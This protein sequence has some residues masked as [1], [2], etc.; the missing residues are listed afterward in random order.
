MRDYEPKGYYNVE[1]EWVST[2]DIKI[3]TEEEETAMQDEIFN[4][5]CAGTLD[6]NDDS[7][8]EP[9]D[10]EIAA[11]GEA[12]SLAELEGD[13]EFAPE[14]EHERYVANWIKKQDALA[15]QQASDGTEAIPSTDT[16]GLAESLKIKKSRPD[17]LVTRTVHS[18]G[19][20]TMVE[21]DKKGNVIRTIW[22][23]PKVRKIVP[24][25]SLNDTRLLMNRGMV[26]C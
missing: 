4:A 2:D 6:D 19:G 5:A 16:T 25:T 21:K 7:E 10:E 15:R 14:T 12:R 22:T 17:L 8:R 23:P 26:T 13:L 18:D 11:A 3:V 9:T 1:N 24:I 20:V